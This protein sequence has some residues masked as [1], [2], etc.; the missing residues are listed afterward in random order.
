MDSRAVREDDSTFRSA[1]RLL[2]GRTLGFAAAF[3]IPVVLARSLDQTEF[4][5]YKQIFLVAGTLYGLG[6]LG[7]A[8]SLLYFMPQRPR[9]GARFA[10]N[11][12]LALIG[13]GLACL[14]LLATAGEE[15]ARWLGNPDLSHYTTLLGVYV[16]LM[17]ASAGLEN[18]MIARKRFG[19]AA[20][21]YVAL[22][23][24]RAGL[25]LA[26]VLLGGDLPGLLVGAV[27]FAALRCLLALG[28]LWLEFGRRD[29]IPDRQLLWSQLAYA[30]P[31]QLAVM[32]EIA[33]ARLHQY[34]VSYRFDVA[35]FAVYSVGCLDIPVTEF[36]MAA[37]VNVLMVRMA[38]KRREGEE[39][40]AVALWHD[41]SRKLAM[42]FFPLTML[43]VVAGPTL[44]VVLFTEQYRASAPVFVV[45]SLGLLF[46]A[47]A[48]DGV[49]RVYAQTR[50]LLVL[51][52]ARLLVTLALIGGFIGAFGLVG[53]A[54]V[55]VIAA[56]VARG[57]G[58]AR[59]ARVTGLGLAAVLPWPS[60]GRI[61]AAALVAALPAAALQPFVS[62]PLLA[63]LGTSG[64]Y[65]VAYLAALWG[66]RAV[67][68]DERA[69]VKR[70][71]HPTLVRLAAARAAA[72]G[73]SRC[74]GS[75][76]S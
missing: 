74:V 2:G 18:A 44:I 20:T 23:L 35:T 28:A 8:E 70:W 42:V 21:T 47:L 64:V 62:L 9:S 19:R 6:Q 68:A 17:L 5:T 75:R 52:L 14:L 38:E 29:L 49:L 43:L 60:L 50:F 10:T 46:P 45:L 53:A 12:L 57:L 67:S 1:L 58:L 3:F 71:L 13:G 16:L 40:T 51:N 55:T 30:I 11:A 31:F 48:V 15:I 32:V 27:A 37:V 24:A 72:E 63:L 26:P 4:G 34:V 25:F 69:T 7:M 41:A 76:E 73:P 59:L 54:A 61:L 66:L 56:A 36:A 22:D 39:A 33:Q 65:S